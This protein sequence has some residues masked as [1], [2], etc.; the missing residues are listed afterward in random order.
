MAQG[1]RA[2]GGRGLRAWGGRQ[3]GRPRKASS[4]P[5]LSFPPS[6]GAFINLVAWQGK[7]LQGLKRKQAQAKDLNNKISSA[8]RPL[9]VRR[10]CCI[11]VAQSRCRHLCASRPH[12][13]W[14]VEAVRSLKSKL[15]SC[16]WGGVQEVEEEEEKEKEGQPWKLPASHTMA[17][18]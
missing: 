15:S 7:S 1:P 16:E 12:G 3:A 5:S 14:T 17:I 8:S 4:S 9:H 10:S 2:D 13:H 6:A 18:L 11:F